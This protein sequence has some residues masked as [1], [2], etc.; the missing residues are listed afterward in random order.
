MAIKRCK[1]PFSVWTNGVPR[2]IAGG[3]LIEDTDPVFK[4]HKDYFEDVET[5]VSDKGPRRTGMEQ[6]TAAPGEK[7]GLR[8]LFAPDDR[9]RPAGE[10]HET[11]EDQDE[12]KKQPF[13][14]SEH[15]VNEVTGYLA[16][17]DPDEALR[18]ID[19]E[20][21]GKKRSTVLGLREQ[22]ET[23]AAPGDNA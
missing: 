2:V 3:Q 11:D 13:N 15:T 8:A 18:V 10:V 4:S 22:Y 20:A 1:S 14:P 16:E 19:A 17:A 6:A 12:S 5:F 23:P 9:E 7:R 21:A